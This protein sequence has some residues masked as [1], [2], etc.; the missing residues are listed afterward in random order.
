M[1][2][3]QGAVARVQCSRKRGSPTHLETLACE[4]LAS[5]DFLGLRMQLLRVF[6][7]VEK[8]LKG[9]AKIVK[10]CDFFRF[11]IVHL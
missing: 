1:L 9:T 4:L 11:A 3:A 6:E 5:F 8:V 10:A 7:G 2:E